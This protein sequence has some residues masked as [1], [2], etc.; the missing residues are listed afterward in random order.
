VFVSAE[1]GTNIAQLKDAVFNGLRPEELSGELARAFRVV[2]LAG[3]DVDVSTFRIYW[4][5]EPCVT[6]GYFQK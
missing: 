2:G 5:N 3:E 4:W 6:I 1:L